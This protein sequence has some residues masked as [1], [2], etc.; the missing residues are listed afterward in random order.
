MTADIKITADLSDLTRVAPT[1][2]RTRSAVKA[3]GR[4]FART[5]DSSRYMRGINDI[6]RAQRNLDP[7]ARRTRAEI[8]RMGAAA[9]QQ[10]L[11]LQELG[12]T[13]DRVGAQLTQ[14]G[15][16]SH[17]AGLRMNRTGVI[18]QQAGYQIGDFI[19]QVQSGTNAFVA[20]GQQ[21]TQ[22]AGTLTLLGGRWVFFGSVLGVIIPLLTAAGA[23]IVRTGAAA[24]GTVSAFSQMREQL[25]SIE[26]IVRLISSAFS[27]LAN[28]AIGAINLMVNNLDRLIIY[29]LSAAAFFGTRYVAGVVAASV[30]TGS[31][32]GVVAALGAAFVFLR[33]AIIATGIGVFIILI[34]ELVYQII[35]LVGHLRR[36]SQ[37][38]GGL[39]NL[40]GILGR[41]SGEVFERIRMGASL[42]TEIF[43]GLGMI[44]SGSFQVGFSQA[45][46][47]FR[48][49][50][51]SIISGL[52]ILGSLWPTQLGGPWAVAGG[53]AALG[54]LSSGI[55]SVTAG[56]LDR[57]R[58]NISG[59]QEVFSSASGSMSRLFTDEIDSVEELRLALEA[60]DDTGSDIDVRDWFSGGVDSSEGGEGGTVPSA[61]EEL[62]ERIQS[63][64]D[65][66]RDSMSSAFMSIVDG[67]KSAKEAFREMAATIIRQLFDILV[68]QRIVGQFDASTGTGS[69]IVGAIMGG[70]FGGRASGGSMVAGQPYLVGERGPEIVVPGRSATVMNHNLSRGMSGGGSTQNVQVEVFVNDNGNFDARVREVSSSVVSDAAPRIIQGAERQI[71]DQ[72]RRGGVY[73]A[74]F[75]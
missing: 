48:Q 46:E 68:V 13:A 11:G 67:T 75:G 60:L 24:D 23:A 21:A 39:G 70:I 65:T 53:Q 14:V 72:R 16:R 31:F 69:G 10:A 7:A 38:V 35:R 45:L 27:T 34:G 4:E 43:D 57:G 73:K 32:T 58:Y 29:I 2:D 17:Q 26:P 44:I 47:S 63:V 52:D 9:R 3:L 8:M 28:A 55:G 54:S 15:V 18:T 41:I 50:L 22:V 20:F 33:Q 25:N 49:F 12:N 42:L 37:A 51:D 66:M 36:S 56:L 74:T 61:L 40:M 62:R 59:G 6:V 30:A 19:V 71:L 5:N 1:L 64:A